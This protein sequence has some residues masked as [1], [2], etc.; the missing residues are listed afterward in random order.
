MKPRSYIF[1][2]RPNPVQE[3]ILQS[4]GVMPIVGEGRDEEEAL[5]VFLT[6]LAEAAGVR[7]RVCRL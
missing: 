6:R 1:M 5:L 3:A 7:R 2:P 4:W